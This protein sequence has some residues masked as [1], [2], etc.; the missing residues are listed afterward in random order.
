MKNY[1]PVALFVYNRPDHTEKTIQALANNFG[2]ANF[3][4]YI[5]SD[6]AKDDEAELGVK[7]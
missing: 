1:P 4:V 5:F 3:P 7:K 2:I 6:A